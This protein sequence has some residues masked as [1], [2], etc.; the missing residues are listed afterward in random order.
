M[1][2]YRLPDGTF[3][4]L[5]SSDTA[6][7]L[8]AEAEAIS[9]YTA[10]HPAATPDRLASTLLRIRVARPHRALIM[11]TGRS[12]LLD[13]LRAAAAGTDHPALVRSPG[14]AIR[15]RI[16]FVFPGQ[17]GQQA[18]MG[19]VYYRYSAEYRAV[20]DEYSARHEQR[21]GDRRPL[22]YLLGDSEEPTESLIA[23]HPARMFHM[24]GLAAMW[25]AVGVRPTAALGHSQ[26]ELAA[27]VSAGMI[28]PDDAVVTAARRAELLERFTSRGYAVAVL[29]ADIAAAEALLARHS[30]W[31]EIAV[32]NSPRML[33]VSGE[34]ETVDD[35]VAAAQQA[36][37]FAKRIQM[38]YP[39]HTSAVVELRAELEKILEVELDSGSLRAGTF[40]CYGGT[41]GE[42]VPADC[43]HRQ[44]WYWNL[45]NRVRFDRAVVAAAEQVDTFLEICEH[46]T[47]Q[48]AIRQSLDDLGERGTD[49]Y[50]IGGTT[51]RDATDL[52]QFARSVA[53]LAVR[54]LNFSWDGLRAAG[55]EAFTPPLRDFP[56]T[57]MNSR[58]LW[59][60]Y[61]PAGRHL[62]DV[63]SPDGPSS[64]GGAAEPVLLVEEWSRLKRRDLAEPRTIAVLGES[65]PD[66]AEALRVQAE[67]YGAVIADPGAQEQADVVLVIPPL[68][69][70]DDEAESVTEFAVFAG[71]MQSLPEFGSR[72]RECWLVT[73]GSEAVIPDDLPSLG[74]AG[75]SAM[76]RS[77]ALDHIGVAFRHLDLPSDAATT[78]PHRAA[79]WIVEAVHLTADEPE[80]A[81]REGKLHVKRLVTAA[82]APRRIPTGEVLILGGTGHVGLHFCEHFVRSG[83]RRVTLVSRKG[84]TPAT[85]Q[86]LASLRALGR[87]DIEVVA[88]DITDET[89]VAGLASRYA[90]DPADVVVHAAVDYIWQ[91]L[92]PAAARTAAAAK[93]LGA[94]EILRAI[95]VSGDG[96]IMLCSSF[97]AS[98]GARGQA[99]YTGTN[100][101]LDALAA[102]VRATGRD[103]VSVQWGL[104]VLP[105][106]ADPSA[107]AR[108]TGAGLLPMPSSSAVATAFDG[109]RRNYL[110]VSGDWPRL[111]ETAAVVGLRN[112]FEPALAELIP[113]GVTE[114]TDRPAD[115]SAP[116]APDIRPQVGDADLAHALRQEVER[117]MLADGAT[118]IDGS[119]PLLQLGF[120]SLLALE[121]RTRIKADLD[122]EVPVAEILSGASLDDVVRLMSD[123]RGR[124]GHH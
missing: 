115:A 110:V 29:A 93:V 92:N 71:A 65:R 87:T 35:L 96:V 12:E 122:R 94:T 9:A 64:R 107:E 39:A 37:R 69:S 102:R 74:H 91:E 58:R 10:D 43:A 11:A 25:Q 30:G 83:A 85:A 40:A 105:E 70:S 75:A 73:A 2:D 18:G 88:C 55:S 4:V 45:R 82:A 114:G 90:D 123:N 61:Q 89:A 119:V 97:A 57:V 108:M 36:G 103:C 46:P 31:A 116:S 112:V 14:P 1:S 27:C 24:L 38:S 117:V 98:L 59:V 34:Q 100:R 101:M 78:D 13:A 121:L 53:E 120:D 86:R 68:A 48:L 33:A 42:Q 3:P 99:L 81:V 15:R 67:R 47:L 95:P 79:R 8:R 6:A 51:R 124:G 20:V 56:S 84:E 60:S 113:A 49:G 26:G 80:L 21:Y 106:S 28:S 16:G 54:D 19:A 104:W 66:L 41:L 76:F 32:L 111:R 77:V 22:S 63:R 5:I 62:G 109:G 50:Y 72:T 118:D 52:S 23:V 7:G 44:Y 17:G